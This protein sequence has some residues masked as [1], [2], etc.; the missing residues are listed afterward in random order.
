MVVADHLVEV[1]KPK[2]D[3]SMR[4]IGTQDEAVGFDPSFDEQIRLIPRSTPRPKGLAVP[5]EEDP[6]DAIR[7]PRNTFQPSLEQDPI[8]LEH[9]CSVTASQA[10]VL[11]RTVVAGTHPNAAGGS[12]S[13]QGHCTEH[14]DDPEGNVHRARLGDPGA[15]RWQPM[16]QPPAWAIR[17]PRGH[18][19]VSL[20][21]R[22]GFGNWRRGWPPQH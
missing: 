10:Q 18:G 20:T 5:L 15:V 2:V 6:A 22:S 14:C 11:P 8:F 4:T 17:H 9:D 1:G 13:D 3:G 19:L 7:A 12:P 21:V 16:G